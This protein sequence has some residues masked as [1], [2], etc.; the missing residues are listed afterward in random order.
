MNRL[1]KKHT[2][3][4]DMREKCT[5]VDFQLVAERS[6]QTPTELV[7]LSPEMVEPYKEVADARIREW[8]NNMG[9]DGSDGVK[10]DRGSADASAWTHVFVGVESQSD[11][12]ADPYDYMYGLTAH[13]NSFDPGTY[14]FSSQIDLTPVQKANLLLGFGLASYKFEKY[15]TEKDVSKVRLV[16]P[17]DVDKTEL[18]RKLQGTTIVQ[19]MINE[20]PNFMTPGQIE[21]EA[22]EVAGMFGA[23]TTVIKGD[24][25]REENKNFPL[26]YAVGKGAIDNDE[27]APRLID[28][29]WAGPDEGFSPKK[30]RDLPLVTLVGKGVAFDTGGLS[31]KT[32][33]QMRNMKYDMAGAAHALATAY[34][35]MDAKLPVR[36]RVLL[37]TV[38]NMIGSKSY[39]VDDI[40][41]SRKGD[42]IEIV[43]T[44]AEGRLI[45]ADALY[46]A[47]HPTKA[48][49]DPSL[50]VDFGTIGWFGANNFPGWASSYANNQSLS[51]EF[52]R[53]VAAE[54]ESFSPRPVMWQLIK[55]EL[56]SKV[57]DLRQCNEDH[58]NYDDLLAIAFLAHQVG[59]EVPWMHI[60]LQPWRD[61]ILDSTGHVQPPNMPHGGHAQGVR[62]VYHMIRDKHPPVGPK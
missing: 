46:E 42:T 27:T 24:E 16:V 48:H 13:A 5:L 55:H 8:L 49:L 45:L 1:Y 23:K 43:D 14:A 56:A 59:K 39:K 37:P 54:Q 60:D 57:A 44:D 38:E 29:Y 62:S 10:I 6:N 35:I 4:R 34:M 52:Y 51:D 28:I 21:R 22:R 18:L 33:G 47:A 41:R 36:V 12:V 11:D 7:V 17:S 31:L 9:F 2:G 3:I 40:I 26:I 32:D 20:P 50:I 25:L 53:A 19:D 58:D 30:R 61:E 15:K